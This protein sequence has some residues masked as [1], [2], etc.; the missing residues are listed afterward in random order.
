L[1]GRKVGLL[2]NFGTVRLKDGIE[3]IIN[4]NLED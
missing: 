2:L 1:S 4:G 3:R